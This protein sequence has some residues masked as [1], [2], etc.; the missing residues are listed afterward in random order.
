MVQWCA[1]QQVLHLHNACFICTSALKNRF[2]VNIFSSLGFWSA[3]I[4]SDQTSGGWLFF[5]FFWL[6]GDLETK[7]AKVSAKDCSINIGTLHVKFKGGAR[8][9]PIICLS[10]DFW[11]NKIKLNNVQL[12]NLQFL[13][14]RSWCE[15]NLPIL[16]I[17][18]QNNNLNIQL[19]SLWSPMGLWVGVCSC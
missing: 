3:I 14:L 11:Q 10:L 7:D 8:L 19:P 12:N 13:F 9:W 15:G 6:K 2:K 1:T 16:A 4:R 17:C 18:P 5:F